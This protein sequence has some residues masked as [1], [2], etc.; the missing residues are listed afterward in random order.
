MS[1]DSPYDVSLKV[2]TDSNCT[3]ISEITTIKVLPT[4]IPDFV[5]NLNGSLPGGNGV[6]LLDGT[7]STTTNGDSAR[8][9]DYIYE[10]IIEDG[11][12]F[13]M[14]PMIFNLMEKK[15]KDIIHIIV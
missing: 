8:P 1:Y 4:P 10:W 6:Y 2:I 12:Y 11:N 9:P 5:T 13:L 7:I 15:I 14:F 3:D